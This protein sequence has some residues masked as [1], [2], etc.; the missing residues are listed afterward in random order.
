[1]DRIT[2]CGLEKSFGSRQVLKGLDLRVAAGEV[3]GLL[4]DNGAGKSTAINVLT[5]LLRPDAGDARVNGDLM[6]SGGR[7]QVGVAPQEAALYPHLTSTENLRFFA[8]VNRL[9]GRARQERVAHV[10]RVL[11][12]Q[13]YADTAVS[14]L[15]GGW[16]R[17]LNLAVAIVHSPT[18][19]ILDEPTAG[20]DVQ[21]R[22]QLWDLIRGFAGQGMAVLLTT[23]MLDEAEA[24]CHRV[25]ILH[26]GRIVREGTVDALQRCVPAAELAE[27]EAED[28]TALLDRARA[29][30]L[31]TRRY[32]GRL[33]LLLPRRVTLTEVVH[34]LDPVPVRSVRLC[35][36]GLSHVFLEATRPHEVRVG[37]A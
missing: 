24:L 6:S 27:V 28:E 36:V 4:G 3:Y 23:H 15:S 32:G 13:E 18:V 10:I 7:K 8:G 26:G 5:G 37:R 22:Y 20:L 16:R 35:P 29:L 11:G 21:T 2:I 34:D 31:S 12:L 17:R 1:M 9:R 19:L 30:G 25:G 14:A 33:T